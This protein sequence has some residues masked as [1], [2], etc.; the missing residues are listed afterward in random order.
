MNQ[1]KL[2]EVFISLLYFL[3]IS[4]GLDVI[5]RLI[6]SHFQ[7]EMIFNFNFLVYEFLLEALILFLTG[8]TMF[9]LTRKLRAEKLIDYILKALIFGIVYGLIVFVISQIYIQVIGYTEFIKGDICN[10]FLKYIPNGIRQGFICLLVLFVA[11]KQ[12]KT[13]N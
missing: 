13:E 3:L 8:V 12:L 5:F 2:S 6:N 1:L 9:Y 10:S 4:L 7:L 11:S